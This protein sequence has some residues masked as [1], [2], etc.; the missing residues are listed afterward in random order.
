MYRYIKYAKVNKFSMA[1]VLNFYFYVKTEP[2]S[3]A[4]NAKTM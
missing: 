1:D 3:I 2:F 4:L